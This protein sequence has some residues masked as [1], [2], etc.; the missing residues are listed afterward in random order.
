M[1]APCWDQTIEHTPCK[2]REW[3]QILPQQYP[4]LLRDQCVWERPDWFLHVLAITFED[5]SI[6]LDGRLLVR[7]GG[8]WCNWGWLSPSPFRLI[9]QLCSLDYR[10][11]IRCFDDVADVRTSLS[12]RLPLRSHLIY[13]YNGAIFNHNHSWLKPRLSKSKKT[14]A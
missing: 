10:E 4:D 12:S 1:N 3:K 7:I 9:Q 14:W 13:K 6:V 11:T 8:C 2:I 5:W